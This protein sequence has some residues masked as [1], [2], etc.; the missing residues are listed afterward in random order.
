MKRLGDET[1][2]PDEFNSMERKFK[3]LFIVEVTRYAKDT[4]EGTRDPEHLG[5]I[6][7]ENIAQIA[8]AY[9]IFGSKTSVFPS[10]ISIVHI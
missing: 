3:T 8:T 2:V 6:L 10:I 9:G 5:H 7:G 1:K 4:M